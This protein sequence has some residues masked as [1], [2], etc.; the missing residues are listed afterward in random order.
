M[1]VCAVGCAC[2]YAIIALLQCVQGV[3]PGVWR[4]LQCVCVWRGGDSSPPMCVGCN[5]QSVGDSS[6]VCGV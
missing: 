4:L 3:M 2:Q 5:V 1:S 6:N